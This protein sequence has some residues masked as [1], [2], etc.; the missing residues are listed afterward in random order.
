MLKKL[1]YLFILLCNV[2]LFGKSADPEVRQL[3]QKANYDLVLRPD[4]SAE[5]LDYLEKNFKLERDDRE[6]L[7]DLRIKSLFYQNKLPEALKLVSTEDDGLPPGTVVLKRSILRYLNINDDSATGKHN[8]DSEVRFSDKVV[9]LLQ[10]FNS[11]PSKINPQQ[12]LSVLEDSKSSNLVTARED[13]LDLA[14]VIAGQEPDVKYEFF[15]KAISDLYRNDVQFRVVYAKYLINIGK[16]AEAEKII[17]QLPSDDLDRTTNLALRLD[18]YD[19]LVKFY[20]FTKQAQYKDIIKQRETL[21]KTLNLTR[22]TAKNKWFNIVEDRFRTDEESLIR[23]RKSLLFSI[24]GFGFLAIAVLVWRYFQINTQVK[25]YENFIAKI[26]L[27]K[28]KKAPQPQVISEK[29]ENLLLKKLED[30]E[31]TEDYIRTDM[32]L[33]NLAKKLE[34]NTKY[35]SETINTH[36]QKNFNAYINE[37]RIN[38]IVNKLKEKPVYRSYKIRYLAEESGFSTHSAFAAVFKSVTGMSPANYIQLLKEKEA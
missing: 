27:L 11:D 14:D 32:S 9:K 2:L 22:D 5:V 15:M 36:K 37:L 12:L 21:T 25:E 4:K 31:K 19:L 6:K 18:Y 17:V 29:T 10:Q 16:V 8:N 20:A 24:L 13:L 23:G 33:Q 7:N 3:F 30:F 35:L 38:Y 34:T 1:I 26:N 28:E